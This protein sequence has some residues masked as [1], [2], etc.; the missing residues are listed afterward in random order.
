MFLSCAAA[1]LDQLR[2]HALEGNGRVV[3]MAGTLALRKY[4]CHEWKARH[5][6]ED[7]SW[8]WRAA[9]QVFFGTDQY[10]RQMKLVP[11]A[12]APL[13]QGASD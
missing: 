10:W 9:A 13:R 1:H 7:G 8:L 3:G 2:L 12:Y 5:V 11:L 6:L 4:I